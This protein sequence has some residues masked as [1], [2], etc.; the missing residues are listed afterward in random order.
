MSGTG[1]V[2]TTT[3]SRVLGTTPLSIRQIIEHQEEL[4]EK[5]H[6]GY[7]VPSTKTEPM[8]KRYRVFSYKLSALS[9]MPVEEIE[10]M[11]ANR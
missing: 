8:V 11:E 1:T 5:Y 2:S 9:G 7:R 6:I 10:R 3:A 4:P